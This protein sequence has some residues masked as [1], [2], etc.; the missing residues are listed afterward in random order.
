MGPWVG[1]GTARQDRQEMPAIAICVI[2]SVDKYYYFLIASS[3]LE[4]LVSGFV[5]ITKF[6]CCKFM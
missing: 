5:T 2:Y 4:D 6:T 3:G 1:G